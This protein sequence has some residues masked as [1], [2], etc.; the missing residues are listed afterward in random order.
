MD[1]GIQ[2]GR[3]HAHR[4]LDSGLAVQGEVAN[5]GVDD[6]AVGGE[7]DA[8]AGALN[9]LLQ[10]LGSDFTGMAHADAS[11]HVGTLNVIAGDA[12]IGTG[13]GDIRVALGGR[14]GLAY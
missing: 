4:A 3:A 1:F 5:D 11:G 12:H 13:H 6:L 7:R 8:V 14:H 10:I 2:M 9:D